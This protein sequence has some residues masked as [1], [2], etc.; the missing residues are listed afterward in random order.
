MTF[1][2]GVPIVK[3][4]RMAGQFAKPRSADMETIN[5]VELPSYRGDIIN[6]PD[7][8]PEARVHDPWR[9]VQA[10]NQSAAT[11]NLLRAFSAGGYAALDRVVNW[12]LD[13]M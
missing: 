13:F 10:Y 1:G 11:L 6:S 5:G 2:G 7:P 12:N 4:G 3:L 9:L 8:T